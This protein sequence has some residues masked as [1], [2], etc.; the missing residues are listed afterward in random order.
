MKLQ[1]VIVF[2]IFF[3]TSTRALGQ[4]CQFSHIGVND[5]LT[6]S[7]VYNIFQDKKGFMWFG[8]S[9]GL[10]RYDGN[11]I[12]IYKQKVLEP[13]KGSTNFYGKNAFEDSVGNI[14]FS[15]RTGIIFYDR[16]ADKVERFYPLNDTLKFNAMMEVLGLK[17]NI[18]WITDCN[19]YFYQYNLITHKL[20][21]YKVKTPDLKPVFFHATMDSLGRIWYS[22]TLAMGC[23]NTYTKQTSFH[24][25]QLFAKHGIT[26]FNE[27]YLVDANTLLVAAYFIIVEY[28]IKQGTYKILLPYNSNESYSNIIR[29]KDGR[30]FVTSMSTGLWVID[31]GLVKHL[32]HQENYIN[33]PAT[34]TITSLLIDRSM[35]LW[36]GCDGFGL[37]R[38]NVG[39]ANFKLYQKNYQPEFSSFQTNFIKCFYEKN[40]TVW[41]GTHEGGLHILNRNTNKVEVIKHKWP[42]SNVVACILPISNNVL[43]IGTGAGVIKFNTLTHQ[44]SLIPFAQPLHLLD[45]HNF[46]H[47]LVKTANNRVYAACR[48][49][50]F[51]FSIKGTNA[52]PI[53][54]FSA[55]LNPYLV[56]ICQTKDKTIWAGSLEYGH[57]YK[58]KEDAKG[59]I[60]LLDTLMRGNSV[61]SFYEDTHTNTLWMASEKGLVKYDLNTLKHQTI[62]TENGLKDNYLYAVLPGIK[63]QLWLSSNSGLMC[64]NTATG[65]TESYTSGDGLQSNEFNTGCYFRSDKGE[66]FFGGINGFNSFYPQAIAQNLITPTLAITKLW[67]NDEE[68]TAQG[69]ASS[70]AGLKLP[71]YNSTLSFEFAALEYTNPSKNKFQYKLEGIDQNWVNSGSRHFARYSSLAPGTYVL[72]LKASNNSGVWSPPQEMLTITILAPWYKQFWFLVFLITLIFVAAFLII[73]YFTTRKLKIQLQKIKVLHDERIRIAKDMHDD[74]GSGISKISI[75]SQLLKNKIS[76]DDDLNRHVDK[77]YTTANELVDNLGQIVWTMNTGNDTIENFL[78]YVREYALDFCDD[79]PLKCKISFME[80]KDNLPM[81]QQV[82]RNVFLVIKETLNNCLKH[83]NATEIKLKFELNK[84]AAKFTIIDNGQ[85]FDMEAT[86]KFGN[87][88]IN[89]Q[90]RLLAV[91]ASYSIKSEIGKGTKTTLKWDIT[92]THFM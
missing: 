52:T 87:G 62:S 70:I 11:A 43:L 81:G 74:L 49:G 68:Y 5:G 78:S 1:A 76:G 28:N 33:A 41:F 82:R 91:N 89:M 45:G 59:N 48:D 60:K 37:S 56:S 40:N 75:M 42:G 7:S 92:N 38:V 21:S 4:Q 13:L 65:K 54:K 19:Q 20:I 26:L 61:R 39:H 80:C 31:N 58:L 64:Y 8:T 36:L 29:N 71:H 63:N 84:N 16:Y 9:D 24:L 90:K 3:I 88:L 57:L 79:T 46:V 10:N 12:K 86:R 25:Q 55:L 22:T 67:V 15:G 6:Q 72:W 32:A 14:Y 30:I 34:N 69:N 73:Q 23:F 83:A 18:L 66:L 50:L 27:T 77:I 2:A 85:G 44:S 35:N 51:Y 53:Q 47:A 17:D